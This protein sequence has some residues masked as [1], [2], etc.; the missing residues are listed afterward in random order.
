MVVRGKTFEY[1]GTSFSAPIVASALASVLSVF[2][3][4]TGTDLIQLAKN[5]AVQEP[6]LNGL[7]RADF[8]CM[9]VPVGGGF[10]VVTDSEFGDLVSV[11]GAVMN[12]A[13]F[14]G[15]VSYEMQYKG[16]TLKR[17]DR[18]SFSFTAGT[19]SESVSATNG[20]DHL[21]VLPLV[22]RNGV[23]G[24]LLARHWEENFFARFSFRSDREF[25]GIADDFGQVLAADAD[26]GYEDVFMRFSHQR[27]RGGSFALSSK[28]TAIGLTVRREVK[29]P[30]G[31]L[32]MTGTADKFVG[33]K[34]KTPFGSVN[35]A[36]SNWN[37]SVSAALNSHFSPS[38]SLS[39][40]VSNHWHEGDDAGVDLG[41][42][43]K[44]RF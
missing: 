43:F 7:G 22:F 6:T 42:Q 28:G 36:E 9:T 17:T 38:T 8:N 15:D 24:I 3:D 35:I 4:T 23:V 18:S 26:F 19:R 39:I 30:I 25:F 1:A 12:I 16:A 29:I 21:Q 32:T 14:P 41:V 40:N 33:G 11:S 20:E 13:S 31:Q 34:A 37:H 10:R 5:C 2:P 44:H 27:A